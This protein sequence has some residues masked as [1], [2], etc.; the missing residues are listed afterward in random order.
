MLYHAIELDNNLVVRPVVD[1]ITDIEWFHGARCFEYSSSEFQLKQRLQA[2]TDMTMLTTEEWN[3][4][5]GSLDDPGIVPSNRF[6]ST[7]VVR[8][9]WDSDRK[10]Y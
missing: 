2:R 1:G 6:I 4:F 10:V 8:D 9:K 7:R 3:Q 5:I